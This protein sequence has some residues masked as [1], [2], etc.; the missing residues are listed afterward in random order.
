[1][2]KMPQLFC[3]TYAGGTSE[4]FNIIEPHLNGVEVVKPEYAGHGKRRKESCYQ[5]FDALSEDMFHA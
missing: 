4:F 5:D 2:Q 3:F 1:M